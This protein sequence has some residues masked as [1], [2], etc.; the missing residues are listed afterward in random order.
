MPLGTNQG[1]AM[2]SNPYPD[3][4][5]DIAIAG[6]IHGMERLFDW[7]PVPTAGPEDYVLWA[8]SA[9]EAAVSDCNLVVCYNNFFIRMPPSRPAWNPLK[10][11]ISVTAFT[12]PSRHSSP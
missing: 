3:F 4:L 7:E 2:S 1:D 5:R 9:C 12:R 6:A 8:K 10:S 11:P